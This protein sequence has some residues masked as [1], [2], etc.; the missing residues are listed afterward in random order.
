MRV[1]APSGT[2]AST[3]PSDIVMTCE[4]A[5]VIGSFHRPVRLEAIAACLVVQATIGTIG[6]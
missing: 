3:L 2:K 6:A 4:L 5:G 1:C